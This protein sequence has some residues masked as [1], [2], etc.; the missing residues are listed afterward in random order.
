VWPNPA[1][2]RFPALRCPDPS[3]RIRLPLSE[4]CRA[5]QAP[6]KQSSFIYTVGPDDCNAESTVALD[7]IHGYVNA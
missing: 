1:E 4:F 5:L 3:R 2:L 6:G 7:Y